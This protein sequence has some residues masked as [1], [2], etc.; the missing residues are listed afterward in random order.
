MRWLQNW[1]FDPFTSVVTLLLAPLGYFILRIVLKY[2][3]DWTNYAVEGCLYWLTRF[4]KHSFAGALSLRRYSRLQLAGQSRFLHV[5]SSVDIDL[6]IDQVFVP[7]TLE[8][9][10][11]EKTSFTHSDLLTVGNRIRVIGD[12]GS[13]KSSLI[14]R[15][16][17]DACNQAISKPSKARLPILI[18]LKEMDIPKSVKQA[19]LESWLYDKIRSEVS[20]SVVYKMS[21]CFESYAT[22]SGILVLLD[23]LDEVSTTEYPRIEASIKGLSKKLSN[24]SG[25]NAIV[26]TTRI[27]FHQQIKDAYRD[28]FP[29]VVLL[30][31]FSP[32]E[33]YEF[34]R[35]W[36]FK[37]SA[38]SNVARIYKELTDRPTLREMCS[39]PLILAMYVA[40]DHA[41]GHVAPPESRTEFYCK[42]AEE[43]IV[44][45]RLAQK[46][47]TPASAKLREQRERIL[48][49]LAYEHI[50]DPSQP[51][52]SLS[53]PA[54]LR[55]TC[56]TMACGEEEAER[57]FRDISKE[58][59]L[60]TEE[61]T[62]QTF[63]FIHL[64]L[65]EF[66][67][68]FEAVQGQTD[69][70]T[71]LLSA[72]NGFQSKYEPQLRSRLLEV[73]PFACGLAPRIRRHDALTDLGMIENRQLVGRC[74]LETKLYDHPR[75][76]EYVGAERDS[77]LNT[78]EESWDSQWLRNL[79]V[80]NVVVRD[81]N[82]CAI[83]S[84]INGGPVDLESFYRSLFAQQTSSLSTLLSSYASQDAAAA[85]RLAE[86]CNIDLAGVF[87]EIIID[88][89]DQAPFFALVREQAEKDSQRVV[90][91]TSLLAEAGLRSV[92][93][94][95][96]MIDFPVVSE[97]QNTVD[98]VAK[99]ER[100]DCIGLLKKSFFSQCLTIA[101][102]PKNSPQDACEVLARLRNVP[103]PGA[104]RFDLL[105]IA[106]TFLMFFPTTLLFVWLRFK[107]FYQQW[108]VSVGGYLL[109]FLWPVLLNFLTFR[110]ISIR[111]G[112]QFLIN[113]R[114]LDLTVHSRVMSRW[115]GSLITPIVLNRRFKRTL[116]E[117]A[118]YRRV[119]GGGV[120]VDIDEILAKR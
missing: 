43:L 79:H 120:F 109:F 89:C 101:L 10:V 107:G 105:I 51:A 16:Y 22:T 72:H 41:A 71:R 15:I 85:F 7:L 83:H 66:F 59:G 76:P 2:A 23:G 28:D 12:P 24:M 62:A 112:Y 31:P 63:R 117:I 19:V 61:R 14:K 27:Q 36:P 100:W 95:R 11:G 21:E 84:P 9:Q 99:A 26:I 6:D 91:W 115:F 108:Y 118:H 80:F 75:W 49:R 4:I 52:N 70:W 60:V 78:P 88:N 34:L 113:A 20:K 30:K 97:W 86:I 45:R 1:A 119:K 35:R 53:W 8:Q 29:Q 39:N 114:S 46:G 32:S 82:W 102:N 38:E 116:F 33:I 94:A 64:T 69:G 57:V 47:P 103:A 96:S 104:Y 87:P 40:E 17:R 5:P 92:V 42:V 56:E 67:A 25:T 90:L 68:A 73:I 50:L 65:C 81:A 98:N 74:F 44:R 106:V 93:V 54:A 110:R 13:G 3:K 55:I 58:T 48:G 111:Q 37:K 77:L 18:E